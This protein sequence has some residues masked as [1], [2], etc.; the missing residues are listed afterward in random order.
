[1]AWFSPTSMFNVY[2][3][4]RLSL[5]GL[6]SLKCTFWSKT[7]AGR[8][9]QLMRRSSTIW[10]GTRKYVRRILSDYWLIISLPRR[11]QKR[12]RLKKRKKRHE[13]DA[14]YASDSHNTSF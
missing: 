8:L 11:K 2:R 14:L 13:A 3:A 5:C 1:M 4:R 7:S 12:K 6:L 9:S 10:S